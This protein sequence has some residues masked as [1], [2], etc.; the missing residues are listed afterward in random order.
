MITKENMS[1]WVIIKE[2]GILSLNWKLE[3]NFMNITDLLMS[4]YTLLKLP[5][6]KA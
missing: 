6:I 4:S 1:V 3:I 2:G 5:F